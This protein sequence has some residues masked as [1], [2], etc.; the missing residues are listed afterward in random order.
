MLNAARYLIER[1][2][3]DNI[4]AGRSWRASEEDEAIL[5][6]L[7]EELHYVVATI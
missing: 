1:N 6:L 7:V 3:R 2:T 5:S 4:R